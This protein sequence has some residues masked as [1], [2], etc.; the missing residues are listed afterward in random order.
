MIYFLTEVLDATWA[1]FTCQT[2]VAAEFKKLEL[3]IE[4]LSKVMF[5]QL[6][7]RNIVILDFLPL[8]IQ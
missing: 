4:A 5:T 7:Q 2:E 6:I 8:P 3:E 1:T